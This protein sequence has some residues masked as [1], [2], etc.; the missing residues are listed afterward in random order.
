MTKHLMQFTSIWVLGAFL[1]LGTSYAQSSCCAT[2]PKETTMT[3]TETTKGCSP[4]SCRGAKTKFGEAKVITQLRNQLLQIKTRLEQSKQP[5]FS[6]RS[7]DIH[8]I[9]GKNDTESLAIISREVAF[10]ERELAQ[11]TKQTIRTFELPKNK[12]QQVAYLKTRL[13]DIAKALY[14]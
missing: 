1:Q 6:Q 3:A 10:I 5:K 2:L 7:Y 4:S 12:A 14:M 8:G 11:K 13:H 9:I